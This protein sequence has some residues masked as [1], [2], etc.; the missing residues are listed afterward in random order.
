MISLLFISG[1]Q[2]SMIMELQDTF[3]VRVNIEKGS[4]GPKTTIDI[5]GDDSATVKACIDRINEVV[6]EAFSAGGGG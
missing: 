5:S 4:S 6:S 1:K 2:G 3:G